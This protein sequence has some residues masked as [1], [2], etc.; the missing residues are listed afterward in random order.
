MLSFL[1]TLIILMAGGLLSVLKPRW[2]LAPS[3]VIMVSWPNSG[4]ASETWRWMGL[5]GQDGFYLGVLFGLV[6]TIMVGKPSRTLRDFPVKSLLIL[7]GLLLLFLIHRADY[8][9][10]RHFLLDLRVAFLPMQVLFLVQMI[11]HAFPGEKERSDILGALIVVNGIVDF[12]M[13]LMR[14]VVGSE[15]GVMPRYRDQSTVLA[16]LYLAYMWK[17]GGK[18]NRTW[19]IVMAMVTLAVSGSRIFLVL[20]GIWKFVQLLRR[21]M[22]NRRYAFGVIFFPLVLI[23]VGWAWASMEEARS[24]DAAVLTEQAGFRYF[25]LILK[26]MGMTSLEKL[27]GEGT[28]AY[29][30]IPWFEY[31]GRNPFN[32]SMDFNYGTLVVKYGLILGPIV[33]GLLILALEL[34][35]IRFRGCYVFL[36]LLGITQVIP[37]HPQYHPLLVFGA[38]GGV[39]LVDINPRR[40]TEP[41]SREDER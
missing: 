2:F 29:F 8:R 5:L 34:A 35:K 7:S 12:V 1:P 11:R 13:M 16:A 37:W 39:S 36:A 22:G 24:F 9:F 3:I 30:F 33:L 26:W 40:S 18:H 15:I 4:V 32:P 10:I 17:L 31:W 28:G 19:P 23:L 6:L 14:L 25:P 20:V 21:A 41:E 27:F 38:L